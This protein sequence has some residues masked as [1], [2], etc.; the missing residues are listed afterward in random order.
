MATFRT[1]GTSTGSQIADIVHYVIGQTV[2][3]VINSVF[4]SLFGIVSKQPG[5]GNSITGYAITCIQ[6]SLTALITIGV[7]DLLYG[8][9]GGT[10]AEFLTGMAVIL[11]TIIQPNAMSRIRNFATLF[12][13]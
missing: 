2:A 9:Y 1:N 11:S 4:D 12:R 10:N 8:D 13:A 5:F 3:I 7:M 6:T